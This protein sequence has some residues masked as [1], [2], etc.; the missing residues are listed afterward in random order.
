M[1]FTVDLCIDACE[2]D[3]FV[4]LKSQSMKRRGKMI[5]WMED[6]E[7]MLD[8]AFKAASEWQTSK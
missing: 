7:A 5:T 6:Q 2:P 3:I 1:I 4:G 8:L